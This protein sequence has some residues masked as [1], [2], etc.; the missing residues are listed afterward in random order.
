MSLESNMISVQNLNNGN[1]HC[2]DH[3]HHVETGLKGN[4]D[5]EQLKCTSTMPQRI[6]RHFLINLGYS[7]TY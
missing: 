7:K 6:W 2:M 3:H 4:P 5:Y 1:C